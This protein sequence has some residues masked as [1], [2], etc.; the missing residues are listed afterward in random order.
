MNI[1]YHPE[2]SVHVGSGPYLS[3]YLQMFIFLIKL[4]DE[5][6]DC[7]LNCMLMCVDVYSSSSSSTEVV[8]SL[9]THFFILPPSSAS[10]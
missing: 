8:H 4:E 2:H 5:A 6:T 7:N 1:Y 10:N 9:G 3:H